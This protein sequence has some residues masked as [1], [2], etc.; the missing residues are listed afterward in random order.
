MK[1]TIILLIILFD[2][3]FYEE[4][5]PLN[6]TFYKYKARA[7]DGHTISMEKFR[8][9]KVL[10]VNVAS[11]CG[12]TPQY[13]GL[14]KLH[15][16]YGEDLAVL[17]FP[18]NDFF[19]QEPGS[20]SEIQS[21]CKTNY[22]ATFQMFEKI[23]VKG[24]EKHPLYNWLSESRLNGW[25]NDA[26]SWNF[27]KYLIDEQG[28]L[29]GFYKSTIEPTDTLITRHLSKINRNSQKENQSK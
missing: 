20:N 12:Y 3:G 22:G 29:L 16:T 13:K 24:K 23:H 25:N 2:R 6:Q 1:I 11:K 8:G 18:S 4:T 27:C 10:I 5:P 19:W 17:G 26:P 28:V 15:E 7:I 9:K 14:Q 21:F